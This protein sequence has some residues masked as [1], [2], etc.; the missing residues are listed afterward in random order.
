M[1]E[2]K[3]QSGLVNERRIIDGMETNWEVWVPLNK[4]RIFGLL[5][6]TDLQTN[7]PRPGR[8]IENGNKI[9]ELRDTQQ[10]F[11]K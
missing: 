1:G 10:A 11:Y 4:F 8:T 5:D 7:R 6:D 9:T 2:L 3:L